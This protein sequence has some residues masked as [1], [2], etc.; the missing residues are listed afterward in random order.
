MLQ[1]LGTEVGPL[2]QYR[3]LDVNAFEGIEAFLKQHPGDSQESKVEAGPDRYYERVE[4]VRKFSLADNGV[5]MDAHELRTYFGELAVTGKRQAVD[6]NFGVGAKIS[7]AAWNPYGVE[8]RSWR[9]GIGHM[10][11][12]A[13][14]EKSGRYGLEHF[15]CGEEWT[16]CVPLDALEG[17]DLMKPPFI[18]D[19]GT[20]VVLL[21]AS[22][23]EDTLVAPDTSEIVSSNKSWWFQHIANKQFFRIPHGIKFTSKVE[24]RAEDGSPNTRKIEGYETVLA[25]FAKEKGIAELSDATVHWWI[26]DEARSIGLNNK[27]AYYHAFSGSK[28]HGHVAALFGYELYDFTSHNAAIPMLQKFGVFAGYNQVVLYVEPGASLKVT[29]NMTRTRLVLPDGSGL[30]WDRWANEFYE[31]MPDAI[32]RHVEQH[33]GQ[34]SKSE[35][36]F[37]REQIKKYQDLLRIQ[38]K[39]PSMA[40]PEQRGEP[41]GDDGDSHVGTGKSRKSGGSRTGASTRRPAVHFKTTEDG[42]G[43]HDVAL[44]FPIKWQW[45][46]EEESGLQDR[47]ARFIPERCFLDINED[48]SILNQ[49]V[50]RGLDLIAPDRRE[51]NRPRI[52]EHARKLYATQLAWTVMSAMATFKNRQEWRGEGFH[53][54]IEPEALTAAVLPRQHLLDEMKKF[55]KTN[56]FTKRDLIDRG[57]EEEVV[58]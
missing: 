14:D 4:G 2:K 54:L 39:R 19:H 40:T 34:G 44:N 38:A 23:E 13:F 35:D 52:E 26:L 30:P 17:S 9:H 6:A 42:V 27:R 48:F 18:G 43:V 5:G 58:A 32:A 57:G 31:N 47:A 8:I 7:T 12:I 41:D 10:V 15:E 24:T 45:K 21:G 29:A 46:S 16:E 11:R 3:E 25:E 53:K 20:V 33:Q 50:H 55:V 28:K 37:V 1:R 49:I 56:P 51:I 36:E 22:A